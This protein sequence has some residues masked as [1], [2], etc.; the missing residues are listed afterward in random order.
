MG[1]GVSELLQRSK[2]DLDGTL[3]EKSFGELSLP[4][5]LEDRPKI[6]KFCVVDDALL[7]SAARSLRGFFECFLV[8]PLL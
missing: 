8:R 6:K 3:V 4:V 2:E 7:C 1:L 5:L